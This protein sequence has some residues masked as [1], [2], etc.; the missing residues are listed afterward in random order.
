MVKKN[1]LKPTCKDKVGKTICSPYEKV[2][3]LAMGFTPVI[4]AIWKAEMRRIM[5]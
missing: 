1:R 4:P 5:V 3:G 2:W